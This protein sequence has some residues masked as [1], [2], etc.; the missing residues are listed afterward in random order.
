VCLKMQ[1]SK[2]HPYATSP[3]P[4]TLCLRPLQHPELLWGSR[5]TIFFSSPTSTIGTTPHVKYNLKSEHKVLCWPVPL[6]WIFIPLLK[7][8]CSSVLTCFSERESC[9]GDYSHL[10][11]SALIW[12]GLVSTRTRQDYCLVEL[13]RH[14]AV[15][16]L[17]NH[18]R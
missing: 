4:Q 18:A 14:F 2:W 11:A 7:E 8:C 13:I 5:F 9:Y 15:L 10:R 3:R 6:F 17:I 16:A 12:V 1:K